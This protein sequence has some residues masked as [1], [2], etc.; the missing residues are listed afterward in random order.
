MVRFTVN[1]GKPLL[2]KVYAA[3]TPDQIDA[4]VERVAL[5]SFRRT[6]KRRLRSGSARF[7][8]DGSSN[9]RRRDGGC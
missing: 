1:L 7:E 5:R 4:V 9:D 6:V 8:R 3:L 2:E